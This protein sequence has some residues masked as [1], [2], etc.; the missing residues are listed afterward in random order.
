MLKN[1]VEIFNST[2]III[3]IRQ[4]ETNELQSGSRL[5]MLEGK[6][7]GSTL[8]ETRPSCALSNCEKTRAENPQRHSSNTRKKIS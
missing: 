3:G 7:H 4:L 8:G 2:K 5:E 1:S 6:D